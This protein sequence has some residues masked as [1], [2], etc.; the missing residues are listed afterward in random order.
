MRRFG[1]VIV[2]VAAFAPACG[3]K[4]PSSA[5]PHPIGNQADPMA[6][7]G[8]GP[9]DYVC[10]IN[11][12]GYDYPPFK[13]VVANAGGHMTLEK[14]EGSVRFRGVVAPTDG[15]FHFDGEVY[16]PWGDCTEPV[17]AQFEVNGT[18]Y[19]AQFASK[20]SGPMTVTLQSTQYGYGG[21]GYGGYGYGGYGYGGYGYGG[22][23]YGGYG[24]GGGY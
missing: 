9:G 1:L 2:V 15:G 13:C 3:G 18:A 23:G 16:C 10:T 7:S 19:I 22:Y 6:Q 17:H 8:F 21:N 4:Q 20:Q 11:E 5:S 24:Y 14:V 12:G